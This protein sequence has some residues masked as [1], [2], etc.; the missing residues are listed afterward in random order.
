MKTTGRTHLSALLLSS[1]CA[2]ALPASATDTPAAPAAALPATSLYQLPATLNNQDGKPFKLRDLRGHPVVVSMFYNSCEFVC[3][4]LIDTMRQT[5]K[6]LDQQSRDRLSMLL[7]TFDP[8]R[9]D[10]KA[11]KKMSRQRELD[12]AHWT[13]AR[14]DEASVRKIAATLDI[15]YRRLESGE[16]NHSTVLVL[17]D[18]DGRVLGR[19]GKIGT[20]DP[21]FVKLIEG[22]MH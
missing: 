9:D 13:V 8:A 7:I 3:P 2:L 17:L 11:L 10:I 5:Q 1:L 19:T 20:V 18:S 4:M 16:Y 22:V 12:P 15:Q 14:T 21:E 6:A